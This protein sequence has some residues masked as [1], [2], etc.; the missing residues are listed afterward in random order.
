MGCGITPTLAA[1]AAAKS[2]QSWQT[3]CNHID[4]SPDGSIYLSDTNTDISD[5]ENN[6][7]SVREL[8]FTVYSVQFSSGQS[9]SRVLLF[10]TP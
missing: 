9:L 1:A 7:Y 5:R 6:Q 4:G 3:L 8:C 10:A 2:L